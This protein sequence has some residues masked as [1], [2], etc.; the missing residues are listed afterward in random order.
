MPLILLGALAALAFWLNDV[1]QSA[2]VT[3]VGPPRHD[4]D[5][6]LGR[7]TARQLAI[8][9]TLRYTLAARKMVHYSDD[10][11]TRLEQV[12][13]AAYEPGQPPV[14]VVSDFALLTSKADEVFFSGDVL[15]RR[16]G[17]AKDPPLTIRTTYL[18][19]VPETGMVDTDKAVVAEQGRDV[20][21][22]SAM[23]L[24]SKT[25]HLELL[26]VKATYQPVAGTTFD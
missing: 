9:G 20:V 26:H 12:E 5:Y 21:N 2:R 3:P 4:P 23:T 6:L 10:D 18:H 11:A 17:V 7:F 14:K 16:E 19:A 22:A 13:F 24:N 1:V 8:D 15:L 25:R